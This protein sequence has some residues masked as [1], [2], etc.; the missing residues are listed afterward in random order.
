MRSRHAFRSGA[1][2]FSLV[3]ML[4]VPA[5]VGIAAV[6]SLPALLETLNRFRPSATAREAAAFMQLARM[7][8]IKRSVRSEVIFDGAESSLVAFADI[9]GN[10][11][12]D[13]AADRTIAGPYRLPPGISLWGP[14]DAAANDVN[15]ILGWDDGADPNEGPVFLPNGSAVRTGA[16]RFRD[17]R[18]NFLEARVEFAGTAKVSIQKWFGGG[19]PNGNRYENGESGNDWEWEWARPATG[20]SPD[21]SVASSCDAG[22]A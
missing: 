3:E 20:L 12:H 16:F 13:P 8:A 21:P 11:N 10:G 18:G 1:R 17:R 7:E 5:L 14:S 4:V 9:D 2:G 15:S 6:I 22:P 19:D